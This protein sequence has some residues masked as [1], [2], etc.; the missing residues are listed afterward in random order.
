MIVRLSGIVAVIEPDGIVLDVNG[1]GYAVAL[2]SRDLETLDV[3]TPV[4][5]WVVHIIREDS[6]TLYGFLDLADRGIFT[7]LIGVSGVGPKIGMKMISAMPLAVIVQLIATGDIQGLCRCPGIGK[8]VAERIVL[9]LRSKVGEISAAPTHDSHAYPTELS[10]A[11]KSLGYRS[12]EIRL[13]I[14]QAQIPEGAS[15]SQ[16]LKLVLKKI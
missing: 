6:W 15:T 9:D 2:T 12:E 4:I 1:V 11:L 14:S 16:A 8:K 7:Q 13:A 5:L 3:G 10:D